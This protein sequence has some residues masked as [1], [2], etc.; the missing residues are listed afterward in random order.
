VCDEWHWKLTSGF[1]DPQE[2]SPRHEKLGRAEDEVG[3]G[4]AD[5]QLQELRGPAG[6][7]AQRWEADRP[8]AES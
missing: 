5:E 1:L 2:Y 8:G 3:D 4:A 6:A 7:Q